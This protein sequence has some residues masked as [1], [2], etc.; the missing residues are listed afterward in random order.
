MVKPVV[1]GWYRKRQYWFSIFDNRVSFCLAKSKITS[2]NSFVEIE[3]KKRSRRNENG[4]QVERL[5]SFSF[6][7]VTTKTNQTR[8]Y[9]SCKF[10]VDRSENTSSKKKCIERRVHQENFI[11]ENT[12]ETSVVQAAKTLISCFS[13]SFLGFLSLF[14]IS[15]PH[16]SS[17]FILHGQGG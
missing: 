15:Q 7:G 14:A 10:K 6:Q 9:C 4:F 1:T 11:V 13:F 5:C 17:V 16:N 8:D 12:V 2:I 3:S